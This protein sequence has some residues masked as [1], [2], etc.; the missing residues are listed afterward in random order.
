M[1]SRRIDL[2]LLTTYQ[3]L[4][5]L[6]I[7]VCPWHRDKLIEDYWQHSNPTKMI[8]C[9]PFQWPFKVGP[10]LNMLCI[11]RL[12]EI[13]VLNYIIA[14]WFRLF[15]EQCSWENWKI[16]KV[17]KRWYFLAMLVALQFT[18]VS[19]WLKGGYFYSF[20]NMTHRSRGIEKYRNMKTVVVR[21]WAEKELKCN[22]GLFA[23]QCRPK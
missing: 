10:V 5:R 12:Q 8:F 16:I 18:P 15:I 2:R 4:Q 17:V 22:F 20:L 14:L 13:Y 19:N 6:S 7:V 3:K 9:L 1:I 23:P 21:T 11:V